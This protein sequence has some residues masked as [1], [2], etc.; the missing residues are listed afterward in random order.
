MPIG[1]ESPTTRTTTFTLTRR[2]FIEQAYKVIGMLE[3]GQALDAEQLEEGEIAL[4]LIVRE[5][6]VSGK[7]RWTVES[8]IHLPLLAN[9]TIYDVERGL[10][11]NVAELIA[12]KYRDAA[13]RDWPLEIIT[14]EHYESISEKS[15]TGSPC[16]IYLTEHRILEE[17]DLHIWP[18]PGTVQTQ[19][20]VQD[21]NVFYR[22]IAPHTSSSLT[23]PGL[24]ANWKMYWEE[25]GSTVTAWASSTDYVSTDQLRITYQRPLLDFNHSD[26]V[27]DFPVQWP[28]MILYKLAFDL[29]DVWSV[30]LAERDLMINKAKAAYKDIF[31]SIK[32][33]STTRHNKARYF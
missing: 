26:D 16:K 21:D 17:R 24:G 31:P 11:D 15:R 29:C 27:P 2:Q 23:Q 1:E 3:P 10:P 19:S 25:G 7:W 4:G 28:R 33:K 6:D 8:A 32:N 5:T 22:C 9:V 12:A 20:E 13:G 18:T 30:P 14:A